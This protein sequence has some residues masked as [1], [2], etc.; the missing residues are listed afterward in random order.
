MN[1]TL[2]T[3]L[4]RRSIRK[5]KQEQIKEEELQLILEAGKFAPSAMNQQPWHFTVVQNKNLMQKINEA[6]IVAYSKSG[7]RYYEERFKVMSSKET[8]L[9]YDAPTLIIVSGDEIARMPINDC[10]LALENMFLAAES[11]GIGSCWIDALSVLYSTEEG[12]AF[13]TNE[14]IVPEGYTLIGSSA[15]GYKAV[16]QPSSAPRRENTV[17]I[18][19]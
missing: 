14:S 8:N 9:M 12:K 15:F 10:T 2:Q 17:T 16:D 3:I 1:E 4:N 19:K 5:Y 18:I 13:L 7:N 11:L 6:C